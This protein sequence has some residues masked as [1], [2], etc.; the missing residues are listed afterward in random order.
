MLSLGESKSVEGFLAAGSTGV[1]E[2]GG[3]E[4]AVEEAGKALAGEFAGPEELIKGSN[5][6]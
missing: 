6:T 3:I 4:V 5:F 1:V 2:G